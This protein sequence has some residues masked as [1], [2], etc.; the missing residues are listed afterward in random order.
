MSQQPVPFYFLDLRS[1]SIYEQ[2]QIEEALLRV[3][4]RNWCIF[5]SGSSA[6]I[7]LGISAK[8]EEMLHL[9]R[10]RQEPIDIYRRFSGGGTV[11]IDEN[12][13]FVTIICNNGSIQNPPNPPSIMKWMTDF[14]KPV[15]KNL[16]FHC[17]END[18]VIGKR[19]VGGNAQYI[20]KNRWLH[21][22]SFLWDY[23][24]KH[25]DYLKQPSRMPNY[26]QNRIHE[27]FLCRLNSYLGSKDEFFA[28]LEAS[29]KSKFQVESM[30]K[31]SIKPLLS[32]PHRKATQLLP[33]NY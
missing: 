30:G 20:T 7:I 3:D 29:L 1:S 22:T 21:H 12:T 23:C 25:M 5:N 18:L 32:I 16:D 13:C 24:G 33:Y 10:V 11:V 26:R 9:E 4:Q 14:Y 19:K 27:D 2:L 8:L 6:A 28:L 17:V 31:E 15:F